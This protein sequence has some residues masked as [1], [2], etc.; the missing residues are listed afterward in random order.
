MDAGFP[1]VGY[2]CGFPSVCSGQ[3]E[4]GSGTLFMKAAKN[5]ASGCTMLGFQ[6][7]YS[8]C[9]IVNIY[10]ASSRYFITAFV[11]PFKHE[12]G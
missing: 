7:H 3:S 8:S 5:K 9:E 1:S 11:A 2:G 6:R 10:R 12:M 4:I